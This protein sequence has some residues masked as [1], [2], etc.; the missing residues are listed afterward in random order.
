MIPIIRIFFTQD[1]KAVKLTLLEIASTNVWEYGHD[2][3]VNE[4]SQQIL[5]V[6][7]LNN[8]ICFTGEESVCLCICVS[9]TIFAVL[10]TSFLCQFNLDFLNVRP[11]DYATLNAAQTYF[12]KWPRVHLLLMRVSSRSLSD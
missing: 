11:C 4:G 2:P 8:I 5:S 1:L 6:E 7:K 3:W 10:K 12:S 9:F